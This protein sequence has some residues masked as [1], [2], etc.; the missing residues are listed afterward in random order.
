MG[1]LDP[2]HPY[3]VGEHCY[4]VGEHCYLGRAKPLIAAAQEDQSVECLVRRVG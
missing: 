1:Y 2:G 4:I 3:I